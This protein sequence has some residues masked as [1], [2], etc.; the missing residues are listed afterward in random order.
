MCSL[1]VGNQFTS[2]H[3]Q[4]QV[5]TIS[6]AKIELFNKHKSEIKIKTK[7]LQHAQDAQNTLQNSKGPKHAPINLDS[8]EQFTT[9]DL[10]QYRK[11]AKM[12][13]I[14]KLDK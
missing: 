8:K 7:I 6:H 1:Q 4:K 11:H 12:E 13:L 5:R 10:G 2:F 14:H 9:L 3:A